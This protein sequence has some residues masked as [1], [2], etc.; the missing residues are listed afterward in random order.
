M[1]RPTARQIAVQLIF[2]MEAN[3]A[4]AEEALK[5]FFEEGHYASLCEEDP[6][7]QEAPD[8]AQMQYIR[9]LTGLTEE[10]LSEIDGLIDR[11][12]DTWKVSRLTKTTLAILRCAV[13]EIRFME[14]IP[15]SAAV[16]EAVE[17]GK[18]F[19]SPQAASYINGILGSMLR[20]GEP[21]QA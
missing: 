16:N 21:E 7:Y 18:K 9:R 19:D 4:S 15:N 10:H 2:S 13:C 17:L 20:S 12:S 6:L 1:T 3:Q 14:E 8:E 5:L 11:Y